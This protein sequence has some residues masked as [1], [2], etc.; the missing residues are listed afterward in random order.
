M[1]YFQTLFSVN[2][3]NTI[4]WDGVTYHRFWPIQV[5]GTIKLKMRFICSDSKFT[6]AIVLSFPKGFNGAVTVMGS[7]IPVRRTSFP[8][9]NF[10]EDTAPA[11]FDVTIN[12]F[13]GEVKLCNGSD[14]IGT[15]QFCKHLSEGCAMIVQKIGEERYRFTCH[16]HEYEGACNNLI[17]EVE[18]GHKT[19]E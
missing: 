14:P 16:D 5:N 9:L 4:E 19:G 1:Q 13:E 3:S 10:W 2:H 7:C 12:D 18:M 17:F 6:Q 8:T 11:E 15:K